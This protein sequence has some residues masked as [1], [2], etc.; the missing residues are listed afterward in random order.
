MKLPEQ[1]N[2]TS[3]RSIAR[4]NCQIIEK[5]TTAMVTNTRSILLVPRCSSSPSAAYASIQHD[6][7]AR[8]GYGYRLR[9]RN[10]GDHHRPVIPAGF[11]VLPVR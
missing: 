5:S 9:F 6:Q 1:P 7:L 4:S 2:Q 3:P 10:D 11:S 8:H